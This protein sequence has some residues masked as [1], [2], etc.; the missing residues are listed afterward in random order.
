[1]SS[2]GTLFFD[3]LFFNFILMR[4]AGPRFFLEEIPHFLQQAA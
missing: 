4:G 3:K 1:M 2:F